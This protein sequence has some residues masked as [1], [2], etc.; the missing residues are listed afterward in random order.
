MLKMNVMRRA[1]TTTHDNGDGT[2]TTITTS[3]NLDGTKVT[4]KKTL[5]KHIPENVDR[6]TGSPVPARRASYGY[7]S[8]EQAAEQVKSELR[9]VLGVPHSDN[10]LFENKVARAIPAEIVLIASQDDVTQAQESDSA[11]RKYELPDIPNTRSDSGSLA[12]CALL[13]MFFEDPKRLVAG[14]SNK[15][16]YNYRQLLQQIQSRVKQ[17]SSLQQANPVISSSRPLGPPALKGGQFAP[18]YIVPP[19]FTGTRRALLICVVSGEGHDL[20]GPP[21]DIQYVHHFLTQHCGFKDKDIIQLRDDQHAPASSKRSTKQNILDGFSKMVRMSNP[22]DVLFIQ[23]TGHGGRLGDNLYILPSDYKENGQIMDDDILKDLIKFL[24]EAVHCTMLVDCC[25]SGVIGDLPYSLHSNKKGVDI[26]QQQT[27]GSYYDTDTREEMI[28]HEELC[29]EDYKAKQEARSKWRNMNRIATV[30]KEM[31]KEAAE[32]AKEAAEKASKA[33]G[34]ASK[35]AS[36][37]AGEYGKV[38]S[39][40]AGEYGKVASKAAGEYG[41]V[42][43]KAAGKAA[44]SARERGAQVRQ[45][46]GKAAEQARNKAADFRRSQ[47]TDAVPRGRKRTDDENASR[48]VP[49][50]A[51]PTSP[52]NRSKT[53]G[54]GH[55]PP[56]QR[57]QPQAQQQKPALR[58]VAT[59]PAPHAMP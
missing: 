21:N 48:G 49:P 57:P 55:S 2:V 44:V 15:Q 37:A 24:P 5:P 17:C 23:Y 45:S 13:Q 36:K 7:E 56:R 46:A 52:M 26:E 41:K 25:Y 22:N 50:M 16:P 8:L 9:K 19:G 39:K 11:R 51:R 1:S 12:T 27:I 18:F 43:S 34:E 3:Y 38:A 29:D 47:T 54:L 6:G 31:A 32:K 35:V 28:E 40:A 42:A 59:A 4:K 53:V 20:K 30:A 33:A 58:R 10:H 14:N